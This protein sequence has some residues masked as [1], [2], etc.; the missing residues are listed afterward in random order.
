MNEIKR[1][2]IEDLRKLGV[3]SGDRLMVHAS[4][5]SIGTFE[6]RAEIIT[7]SILNALGTKGTLMMPTLSFV[8]VSELNPYFDV[9]T[10]P[11]CAG[12]LSEYFRLRD[13]T[14]RSLHPTHSV[15]GT[16]NDAAEF[17]NE[18]YQ[19]NTPVGV[20][21]PFSKL[22]EAEGKILFIG[23]GL[24]PNTSMHG[25]EE[26]VMPPYLFGD[27]SKYFLTDERGAH[28]SKVY[29]NHNFEGYAQRYER[30]EN[31]LDEEQLK[32]GRIL[33]AQ[34]YLVDAKSMWQAAYQ[35]L[36]EDALYFVERIEENK[37]I[38]SLID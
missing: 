5:R 25:V 19:D 13:D 29:R 23:C 20:H 12:A 10:T 30:I 18:H 33:K 32:K 15:A 24:Q 16:G 2:I 34:C 27:A 4:L 35:K 28:F 17:L 36:R 6:N 1:K 22:K 31:L 38:A 26:L 3:A 37:N 9:K 14:I 7:E 21:S 11:S 8:S